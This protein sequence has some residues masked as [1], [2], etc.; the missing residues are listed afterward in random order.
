M[1]SRGASNRPPRAGLLEVAVARRERLVTDA[2]VIQEIHVAVMQR[3]GIARIMTFDDDFPEVPGIGR[4]R[5]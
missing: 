4:Y 3:H 2:E 1:G 5:A